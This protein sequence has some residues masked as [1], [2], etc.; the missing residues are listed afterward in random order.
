SW[1]DRCGHLNP[2]GVTRLGKSGRLGKGWE[3]NVGSKAK[4]IPCLEG[5]TRRKNTGE[6]TTRATRPFEVIS[7]DL[8]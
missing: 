4:C 8:W 5:K 7:V 1:H 2:A 6:G 3:E